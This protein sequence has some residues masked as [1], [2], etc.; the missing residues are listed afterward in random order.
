MKLLLE[1]SVKSITCRKLDAFLPFTTYSTLIPLDFLIIAEIH[2][3]QVAG[4]G[5]VEKFIGNHVHRFCGKVRIDPAEA[6][7]ENRRQHYLF[8]I[9][10]PCIIRQRFRLSV[11][12]RKTV[13]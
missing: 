3:H 12:Q 8:F 6:F 1:A 13:Y 10:A 11:M 2:E 4:N 7:K 9:T 5:R